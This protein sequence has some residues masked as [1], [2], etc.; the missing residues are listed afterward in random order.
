MKL[1][2]EVFNVIQKR[3]KLAV[4]IYG[5]QNIQSF[6][7]FGEQNQISDQINEALQGLQPKEMSVIRK[8]HVETHQKL[9]KLMNKFKAEKTNIYDIVKSTEAWQ[10]VRY[11]NLYKYLHNEII[12]VGIDPNGNTKTD[13]EI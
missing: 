11:E 7:I 2:Q 9:Y 5:D 1:K 3:L 6:Q 10:K 8:D 13:W 4:K 12:N